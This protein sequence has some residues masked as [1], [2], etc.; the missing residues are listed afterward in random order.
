LIYAVRFQDL[1][2]NQLRLRVCFTENE[3]IT[4]GIWNEA[5]TSWNIPEFSIIGTKPNVTRS[6]L[7]FSNVHFN[8]HSHHINSRTNARTMN[9]RNDR[10]TILLNRR[11][12]VL[13]WLRSIEVTNTRD[14]NFMRFK[15]LT[16][17][18]SRHCNARREVSTVD[19]IRPINASSRT[20][21]INLDH[22]Q[23]WLFNILILVYAK[24]KHLRSKPAVKWV[25][26]LGPA[27]RI[28][29]TSF[30]EDDRNSVFISSNVLWKLKKERTEIRTKGFQWLNKRSSVKN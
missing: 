19:C 30:S 2:P 12:R 28:H 13:P 26:S 6:H 16:F 9:H 29:L 14:G 18:N 20:T 7:K 24:N 5:T 21:T 10:Y 25:L 15:V 22:R 8:N 1:L 4:N 11:K 17:T 27:I 3:S 23:T